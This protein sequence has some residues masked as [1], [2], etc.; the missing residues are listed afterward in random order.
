MVTSSTGERLKVFISYSRTDSSEFADELVAGLE[1][2]GFAPFLD[3]H[4]IAAGEDWEARLGGLIA[5]SDTVVFVVSPEAVKSERCTWEVNRTLEL[6][7]RLLPVIFKPVPDHYIPEKLKRLLFVR[8]DSGLGFARPLSQLAEALRVDLDWIREHTRLEEIATRWDRRGRPES[9]L[10]RGD[11]LMAARAWDAVRKPEAPE[12]TDLQRAFIN[13]STEAESARASGEREKLEELRRAQQATALSKKPEYFVSYAWGDTTPEGLTCEAVVD[14]LC[15]S[16]ER[17][18]I[19]ILRDKNLLGL[20]KRISAFMQRL[21]EGDRVFI[22]LSDKYLKSSFCMYELS[23]V[24]RNCRQDDEEFLSRVRVYT[25]PTAKIWSPLERAQCAVHWKQ[26]SGKLEAIIKE[27]G[28][29]I[30]GDKDYQRYKFMKEFSHSIGNILEAV[31][32]VLQPRSFED[33]EKYGFDPPIAGQRVVDGG[34]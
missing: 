27:H 12:I 18:G 14:R 19:V 2:A 28:Y 33:F 17:R 10:L 21:G 32:D 24:W 23:E 5:Q 13:S 15:A 9:L 30:L 20:G 25:L 26:E 1:I 4:D 22:V 7:K 3:R 11:D 8:F 31:T 29:D 6:S 16:A 34:K